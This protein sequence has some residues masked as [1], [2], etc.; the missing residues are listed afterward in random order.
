MLLKKSGYTVEYDDKLTYVPELANHL[1]KNMTSVLEF[2]KLDKLGKEIKIVVYNDLELYKE[3]I[4]K[5]YDYCD[6]MCA[7]TNDG[8]LNILSLEEAH[9]TKEHQDMDL[10]YMKDTI[11][12]EFIHL[13]QQATQVE[14]VNFEIVW[15]WEA[16]ATN[17]GNPEHFEIVP[18]SASNEEINEFIKL[19][20]NYPIAYTIGNYMLE[21]Y[22]RDQILDYVKYPTKLLKDEEQILDDAK[23]WSN[24]KKKK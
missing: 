20:N 12:H 10:E 19:K 13:C 15:F 16:L 3:H 9:K 18:I 22:S 14:S 6:Y 23:I 4:K 21:N 5:F 24:T 1:E 7:D 11:K 17:L 8:N 2:F